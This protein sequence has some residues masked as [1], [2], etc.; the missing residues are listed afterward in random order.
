[1]YLV[2]V[3][4]G[5]THCKAGLCDREGTLVASAH[6]PTPT[7]IDG[8]GAAFYDPD[9]LWTTVAAT[10]RDVAA[11]RPAAQIAAIG[12]ASMA[13][14]GLL[15]DR[16]TGAARTHLLPWFDRRPAAHAEQIAR[17]S[18]RFARFCRT[19]QYPSFKSGLAKLLWLRAM[20]RHILDGATWLSTADY[21]AYR[22][23]GELATDY[24]LAARTYAFRIDRKTWDQDWLTQW[25]LAA[26]LFPAVY[27]SG[28]P[29]GGVA[30][31]PARQIGLTP[32]TPV[33]IAGHDHVCAAFGVGAIEPASVFDSLGTAETL[34]GT[35]H[36]HP[37]AA[38][39]YES[40]L[41][42]GCHVVA[43][44]LYWMG[45][46]SASGGS[47][48]WLRTLL[49]A[50]RLSYDE[51]SALVA[52]AGQQPTGILYIP[53]LLGSGTPH[54][55]PH[56]RGAFVGLSAGHAR[57]HVAKAVL[58]GVAYELEYIRRAAERGTGSPIATL[59]AAGGGTRNHH[60]M[61]IKADVGGCRLVVP[62]I[63]EATVLGAALVAGVGCRLY[64]DAVAPG[65]TARRHEAVTFLPDQ[66][67]HQIY[68]RLYE[69]GYLPL[70]Q[71]LRQIYAHL[72]AM[73]AQPA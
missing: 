45:G 51:L 61:Q 23:T 8:A 25:G 24:T 68:Q 73:G 66:A 32:G 1:M 57:A 65:Q 6:R 31:D 49:D 69:H 12:I 42:Y 52:E 15:I 58:E 35:L 47:V 11:Q 54:P 29:I 30:A 19:G 7:Q 53:Y 2:G 60:W 18:D 13:E 36:E 38:R 27:P 48:E 10:I 44:R 55:D 17:E 33:A 3:D 39:E 72:A 59:I 67:R 40:G 5:T 16:R 50:D 37:L 62:G 71:P 28:V 46:L 41:T 14:T 43:D 4:I 63:E 70:Q 64:G 9:A 22:L 56:A 21:I 34:I 20:Q 26:D